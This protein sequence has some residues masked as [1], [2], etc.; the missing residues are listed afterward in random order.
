VGE[1]VIALN[2][3][4]KGHL[5]GWPFLLGGAVGAF[6][7]HGFVLPHTPCWRIER[8]H[9]LKQLMLRMGKSMIGPGKSNV[10]GFQ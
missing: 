7:E 8:G 9:F 5:K 6:R 1:E 4:G 3:F 10:A 2:N